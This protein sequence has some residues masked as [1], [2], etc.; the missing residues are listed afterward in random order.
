MKSGEV[1]EKIREFDRIK[2]KWE[3]WKTFPSLAVGN[4]LFYPNFQLV[5]L[6]K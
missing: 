6:G 2:K 1:G 5:H 3:P 4:N